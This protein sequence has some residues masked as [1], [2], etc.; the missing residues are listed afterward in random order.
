MTDTAVK[1]VWSKFV[2][3]MNSVDG[4]V[5][6]VGF[7][8]ALAAVLLPDSSWRFICSL[9]AVACTILLLASLRAKHSEL[10]HGIR[11]T[12]SPFSSHEEGR[13]MKKLVFDDLQSGLTGR[14]EVKVVEH[15]TREIAR[16]EEPAMQSSK[17]NREDHSQRNSKPEFPARLKM[18]IHEFQI[19]DFFDSETEAM[20]KGAQGGEPPELRGEFDFLL[21]KTLAVIKEVVF[22][23]TVA[24]FWANQDKQQLVCEAKITDSQGFSTERRF[25]MRHDLVS[26]VARTGKPELISRVNPL[27]EREIIQYYTDVE[28]V[29]S[30]VGVPV[31]FPGMNAGGEPHQ[32]VGVIAVD[33]KVEDAFGPETVAMFSQFTKLISALIKSSTDKYDLLLDVELLNAIRRLQKH[34]RNDFTVHTIAH[35]LTEEAGKLLHWNSLAVILFDDKKN[36]WSAKKVVNRGQ[37]ST[38]GTGQ[39]IDL[40]G[41][42]AGE[43]IKLNSHKLVDDLSAEGHSLFYDGEKVDRKGSFLSVPISSLNKC[44]GAVVVQSGDRYNFSRKDVEIL[45][46]LTENAASALEIL[47][48]N[49]I[50]KEYVIIDELTGAYTKKFFLQ[51]MDE[52]LHRADDYGTDASLLIVTIDQAQNFSNRYGQ[53]GLEHVL[54]S[55]ANLLRA[56]VRPYDV[57]GRYDNHQFGVLLV[58][59]TANDAYIW[60]EK[61]RKTVSSH[62]MHVD[63]KSF[64]VTISIGV[65]GAL[66]GMKTQTLM[67]NATAVL[68]KGI[69]A[70][71]NAVRIF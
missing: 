68:H 33:S 15:E 52:E 37:E 25:P 34:I 67:D 16:Q 63:G 51:K 62:V 70:G 55:L 1:S 39:S 12:S 21:T 30:F 22:G 48:M 29:K 65:S 18:A 27:S 43:T 19:S 3:S 36:T 42:L 5:L 44:Y 50:I 58:N 41:S 40:T 31:F 20:K 9:A 11:A 47:H 35:A 56:S 61:M 28:Y 54:I 26:Q 38:V 32:P 8:F 66:E 57:I 17:E 14:Y 49:D 13:E 6:L 45:Y 7:F 60:A 24:F 53:E 59:T 10:R 69:E 23:H 64:S 71:G 4:F 46:R 2:A